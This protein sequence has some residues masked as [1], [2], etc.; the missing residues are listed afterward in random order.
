[1]WR[2]RRWQSDLRPASGRKSR[3]QRQ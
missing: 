2:R 3:D 1:V